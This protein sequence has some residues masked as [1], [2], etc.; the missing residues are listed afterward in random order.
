MAGKQEFL[1]CWKRGAAS[2][3]MVLVSW[4][5][6]A[7]QEI[8]TDIM[9]MIKQSFLKCGNSNAIDSTQDDATRILAMSQTAA[10]PII[11]QSLR[12]VGHRHEFD[13][14]REGV[15]Y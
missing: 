15:D 14:L 8:P 12:G 11:P 4:V 1:Q 3:E 13:G 6:D 7:W 5:A 10:F 9:D 2:R